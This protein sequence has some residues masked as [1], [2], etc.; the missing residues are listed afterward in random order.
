M[1][2]D[3]KVSSE[4]HVGSGE[5]SDNVVAGISNLLDMLLTVVLCHHLQTL[6]RLVPVNFNCEATLLHILLLSLP[7]L[8]F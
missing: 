6:E 1:N 4:L 3:L 5:H 8:H 7:T 2:R